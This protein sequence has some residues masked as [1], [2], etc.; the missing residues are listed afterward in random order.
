MHR[1]W[2]RHAGLRGRQRRRLDEHGVTAPGRA[3]RAI[4]ALTAG[5]VVLATA[6]PAQADGDPASDILLGED[7][8]FPYAPVSENYVTALTDLLAEAREK[9]FPVKVALIQSA[10]D[11]GAYPQLFPLAQQYADLLYSE[12]PQPRK[13]RHGV[14][15]EQLLRLLVVMPSGIS[16]RNL[17]DKVDQAL[18][19]VEVAGDGSDDL[20]RAALRAVPKLATANGVPMQVPAAAFEAGS[21]AAEDGGT[22]PI[23][24]IGPLILV[25]LGAGLAGRVA[26]RKARELEEQA[27]AD[28]APEDTTRAETAS[29]GQASGEP[30][31]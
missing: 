12:L 23:V 9:G 27:A 16:G 8:Y 11:L 31:G 4:V 21:G 3:L 5:V 29:T 20:A 25:L 22:N 6:A 7:V 26:M 1:R 30:R 14:E 2:T 10:A 28:G 15:S 13:P 18:A 17:G 19:D 24:F